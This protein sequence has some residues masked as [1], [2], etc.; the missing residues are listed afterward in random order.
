MRAVKR[1][2]QNGLKRFSQLFVCGAILVTVSLLA[3]SMSLATRSAS[4]ITI[5]YP[6]D[7]ASFPYLRESFVYGSAPA[8]STVTVNGT[9]ALVAAS[10]GWIAYIPLSP[11]PLHLHVRATLGGVSSVSDESIT[12]SEPP[13]SLP[14]TP[15]RV[16]PSV[17]PAPQGDLMLNP[18]DTV[19]LF[20]KANPGAHVSASL[21]GHT[22]TISLVET[23]EPA[24]NPSQKDRVLGDVSA[25]TDEV[26]G[27]YQADIR[28]PTS[29]SGEL[30]A[31]YS[32]TAADGSH[33]SETAKGKIWIEPTGWY[34][35]GY[36]VLESRQKDI[37]A[38]PFG[39]V[40]SQPDGGWLFFPPEH[41]PF[42]ITGSNGDYYRVALGSA[43]E[44]WIAKKS[45]ALA[46]QG[47]PRP[48]TSVE[49]VIV[50]DGTRTSS[51]TIHLNARVPF[52]VSEST[53]PPSLQVRL[54]GASASTEFIRYGGDRSNVA[55]VRWDQPSGGTVTIGIKLR[56][57]T[58]WG[59]H[60]QWAKNDLQLTIKKP[61]AFS[62]S[63]AS[64]LEGL[65]VVIDPGHSP[66]SGSIGPLGT[67][68]RDVNLS[69]A[70][71][72]AV[73]LQ[74]FGARTA[75]TR[76]ANVPVGLYDRTDLATRLDADVLVSVHNNALP[77]GVDPFTHHGFSVYYY[78]PQSL[79]LARAI[80]S[81][82][83]RD[84][85]LPDY[86]LYYDNLALV[87]P[88]EEPAVLTESAFIMWPPE[89]MELR[90]PAF[91]DRL[92]ATIAD[93]ID[94]WANSMRARELGK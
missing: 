43:E 81:A 85:S 5:V 38:R 89:E 82:Y 74:S 55:E 14:A 35:T 39:I 92:G 28:I 83:A 10:G 49:G 9:A 3:R 56:Q 36:I 68:E 32:V 19:H 70:K 69:I 27:L 29:A 71:R 58:L 52:W 59:Y 79:E 66:D 42:E 86:G 21:S 48:R 26:G 16:D 7:G 20:V 50:L 63:P 72:L 45:L 51:V 17:A 6:S 64:A 62:P 24:L 23:K 13:R 78:Q 46:P 44:G 77:D 54:F 94:R 25:G 37:D 30:S 57:K 73:H 33:A 2:N 34:R 61:P 60:A 65:L 88:T 1:G 22:E 47:T 90:S 31:V 84:T 75:L 15:A 53:D 18:G 11:G 91:Q 8:G 41:T 87:R 12:I 93:G 67:Q 76:T 4:S 40:Q 80:H